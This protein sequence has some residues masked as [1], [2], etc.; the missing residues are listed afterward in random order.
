MRKESYFTANFMEP[1]LGSGSSSSSSSYDVFINFRGKDTR[2]TLVGHLY[3]ALK[4]RGIH[5]FMDSKNLWKGGDIGPELLRAIK[6]SKL[7]IAV[8][9]ERYAE[10]KWCLRELVQMLDCH[11]SIGQIIF[12]IFYKVKTSDVKNHTASFKISPQKH[13]KETPETLQRWKDALR[14]VGDKSGWVFEDGD[15]QSELV[16]KVVQNAWIRLS[17]VPLIDVKHPVGLESR[18]KD[19]LS[20][21]SKTSSDQDVQFLGICGSGGIGKTT[22][23]TAVYNHIFRNFS[24]SCF[25][26]EVGEKA[27]QPNGIDLLQE[28]LLYR[29][30]REEIKL[31]SPKEG[32]RLIKERLGKIDILLILDNVSHHS[33]IDALASDISWFGPRSRIII[34]T[35]DHGIL[36]RIPQNNRKVYEP[37]ELNTEESLQLFSSYAFYMDQPPEDYMQLSIHIVDTTGGL[38]LALV[39]LGSDLSIERNKDVWKSMIRT[40]QQVP[41]KDVYR[42]LRISY[43][44]LHDDIEKK[45]FLDVACFFLENEEE[46]IISIWE[47]CGFEPRYHLEVLKRKSLLNISERKMCTSMHMTKSKVLL[48]HDQIRDMGRRI[49]NSQSLIE[50]GNHIRLWSREN[51]M[52][53]LNGGEENEMVGAL[54]LSLNHICLN[55]EIFKKMTNLRFLKVDEAT[56]EG[57]FQCL[58]P[59]LRWLSW[60]CPLEELS[61][62]FYHEEIVMLDLSHGHFRLAWNNWFGNKLFQQLKV[63]KLSSCLNLSESP[64]FSGFPHLERLYL[65][66]CRFLVNLHESIGQ[67]QWLVYLNLD[68]CFS[69]EKLPNSICGLSSLQKLILSNCSLLRNLPETIGDLK[70]SLVELFLDYTIIEALPD[71]V[72]QLKKLEVLDLSNC[73]V[74]VRLPRL[75]EN[76]TSLRYILLG[77]RAKLRYIP[78]L[79]SS[80][81]EF[82]ICQSVVRSWDMHNIKRLELL[83]LKSMSVQEEQLKRG[84]VRISYGGFSVLELMCGVDQICVHYLR[85]THGQVPTLPACR[86]YN[87]ESRRQIW[88]R[89][90]ERHEDLF[91]KYL[92]P[93]G[94]EI[95]SNRLIMHVSMRVSGF[96]RLLAGIVEDDVV[97]VN[98]TL[99]F[100]ARIHSRKDQKITYCETRLRMEDIALMNPAFYQQ[101]KSLTN[102]DREA[103]FHKLKGLLYNFGFGTKDVHKSKGFDHRDIE[104]YHNLLVEIYQQKEHDHS[105][106]GVDYRDSEHVHRFKGLDWFGFH[107]ECG[108]TIEILEIYQENLPHD[109]D[110]DDEEDDRDRGFYFTVTDLNLFLVKEEPNL[111]M[112]NNQSIRS[113]VPE[114]EEEKTNDFTGDAEGEERSNESIINMLLMKM[115]GLVLLCCSTS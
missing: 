82:R 111:E 47:A 91:R 81:I 48:M 7:S 115:M 102:P 38:P 23:A 3:R 105:L 101:E 113:L 90:Q 43:D 35:R 57:N 76:M 107:L 98:T 68:F 18:V 11:T 80:L 9:S 15:D 52:K 49:A 93:D 88:I 67:L 63:L 112:F 106:E 97:R 44:N 70:E 73:L 31:C 96:D 46:I 33:Q 62:N 6:G 89:L 25:L 65:D 16:E 72:G 19:V 40:L 24:K 28:K 12:P 17:S 59:T 60:C 27:S 114:Q 50:L 54:S 71:G 69:L 36:G 42:K 1:Q 100:E 109:T 4:D 13:G 5:V 39:V 83:C 104:D 14:A 94:D 85:Q 45:M 53:V 64:D 51:I 87:N 66:G 10:S 8:F 37:N 34:T 20:L 103:Y 78:K 84:V 92:I 79:P 77:G 55:T 61:C 108:D 2:N 41:H 56:L 86:W 30:F 95:F 29:V 58:P 32:S 26:D 21:L 99:K 74:L 22:I 110:D 75:M